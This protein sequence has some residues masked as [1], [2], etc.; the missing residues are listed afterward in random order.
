[1][2]NSL[3]VVQKIAVYIIHLIL[4]ITFHEASHAYMAKKYGDNT[5]QLLG[6]LSLNPLNHIDLLGTIVFPLFSIMLGGFIFGWAKP[7]PI[8]FYK[9]YKPKQN[10]FWVALAGPLSNFA[11]A[12]VWALF[13]KFSFMIGDYFG[14]PLNLMAQAGIAINLS[15]MLLNLLPILP[16]DGGRILYSMLPNQAAVYYS[17]IEPYG[18][19]IL[20]F[21][22]L[23]GGLSYIIQPLF[24]LL[25]NFII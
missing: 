5:A 8:N 16:L 17:R 22:L 11:Q 12:L 7:V 24:M 2:Y 19:W 23:D 9:L 25:F 1:M 14:T 18:M 3:S 6:R 4:A 20:I 21:L 13:L 15:L 10:I